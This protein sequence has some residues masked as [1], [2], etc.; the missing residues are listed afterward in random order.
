MDLKSN[1]FVRQIAK[2][3]DKYVIRFLSKK[4]TLVF[5]ATFFVAYHLA[6]TVSRA[7]SFRMDYVY[8]FINS[9]KSLEDFVFDEFN[10]SLNQ[11]IQVLSLRD[12]KP[13]PA[14]AET[15]EPET[16]NFYTVTIKVPR[17]MTMSTSGE[18][19]ET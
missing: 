15:S 4:K 13:A 16:E 1:K 17:H 9:F 3:K 18:K 11:N 8:A 6:N 12:F 2:H 5:L 14:A 10:P 7:I 19:E